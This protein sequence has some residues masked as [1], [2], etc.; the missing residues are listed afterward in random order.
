MRSWVAVPLLLM[1]PYL[2][3][4]EVAKKGGSLPVAY[5]ITKGKLLNMV[6]PIFPKDAVKRVVAGPVTLEFIIDKQGA[7]RSVRITRGDPALALAVVHA[8]QQWRWEP[9]R[10]NGEAVEIE[11]SLTVNLEPR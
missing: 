1:V 10:L 9:Y 5:T 6:K 11:S 4:Q 8:V 7:T 2:S 3:G